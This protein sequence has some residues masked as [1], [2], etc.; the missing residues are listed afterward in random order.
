MGYKKEDFFSSEILIV[1]GHF[2]LTI[3]FIIPFVMA[4]TLWKHRDVIDR[5]DMIAT[6]GFLT[7]GY[8][9]EYF[10]WE[11]ITMYRK[12]ILV[13]GSI[14]MNFDPFLSVR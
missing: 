4:L 5:T 1:F 10:Y 11:I 13:V 6:Y 3:V 9:S 14:F 8:R 12:S 2:L 7:K